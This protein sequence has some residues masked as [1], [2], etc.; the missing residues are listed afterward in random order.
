MARALGSQLGRALSAGA[1]RLL[2]WR[3]RG[4]FAQLLVAEVVHSLA[5]P[6]HDA[7][8]DELGELDLLRYCEP[9]LRDKS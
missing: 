6:T 5:A 2:L 1:V 4:F 3:A 9:F 8:V 7:V